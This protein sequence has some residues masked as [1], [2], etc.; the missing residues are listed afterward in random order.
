M[1]LEWDNHHLISLTLRLNLSPSSP[2]SA[3]ACA[4]SSFSDIPAL[5]A[6]VVVPGVGGF[7]SPADAAVKDVDSADGRD[8]DCAEKVVAESSSSKRF[9]RMSWNWICGRTVSLGHCA[10][11]RRMWRWPDWWLGKRRVVSGCEG[12]FGDR[13]EAGLGVAQV[14]A[15]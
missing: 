8:G 12:R 4:R 1:R 14:W 2:Y 6:G 13:N 10:R 5:G 15:V 9:V 11:A 7:I 3:L